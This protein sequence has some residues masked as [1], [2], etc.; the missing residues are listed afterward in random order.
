MEHLITQFFSQYAYSPWL[1]YSA[2]CLF[3]ILSAFGLPIPE[4]IVL[5]SA[6]F[7][8]HMTLHPEDY[9]PPYPGAPSVNMHVLAAVAL[10]AVVCSDF[11][12]YRLG[13]R[14]GPTIFKMKWFSRLVSEDALEKIQRWTKKYGAWA[15]FIFRFTP[16]VRFPGHLMCGAMELSAWRFIAVDFIAAGIS[17]PTQVLLVS[18]YGETILHYFKPFKIYLLCAFAIA[19][20]GFFGYRFIQRALAARRTAPQKN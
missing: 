11:L 3:M 7:V 5:I 2:I 14:F 6:G 15:V 20:I 12:I 13:R 19:L 16:G 9:P 10:L 17:V 1:V 8:G 4:E 18:L